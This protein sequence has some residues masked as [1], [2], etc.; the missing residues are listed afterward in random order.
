MAYPVIGVG[1]VTILPFLS[2]SHMLFV[3]SLSNKLMSIIQVTKELNRV[4]LIYF[5]FCLLQDILSKEIIGRGTKRG[6]LYYLDDFSSGKTNHMQTRVSSKKDKSGC[7]IVV[8]GIHP[9]VI[10]DTYF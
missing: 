7:G 8:W 5:A 9:L 3:P 6:G 10:Y 2:L 4:V 1:T